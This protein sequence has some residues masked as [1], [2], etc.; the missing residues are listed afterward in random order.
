VVVH[1]KVV[2]DFDDVRG[3]Q[4]S[5]L[6]VAPNPDFGA[7]FTYYLKEDIKSLE[8]SASAE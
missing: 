8:A 7:V 2:L 5:Q 6:F 1:R 3:S 4:G